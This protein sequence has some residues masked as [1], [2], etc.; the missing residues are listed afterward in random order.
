M[1][2]KSHVQTN[3]M[4]PSC[5]DLEL[6][7]GKPPVVAPEG[8]APSGRYAVMPQR[9]VPGDCWIALPHACHRSK[10]A[11]HKVLPFLHR[12]IDDA[13][14][15]AFRATEPAFDQRDVLLLHTMG[16]VL[17]DEMAKS[18]PGFTENLY[19][20]GVA[21]QAMTDPTLARLQLRGHVYPAV[22][23]MDEVC[24]RLL[25]QAAL[26]GDHKHTSWLSDS[27]EGTGLRNFLRIPPLQSG[28]SPSS[29]ILLRRAG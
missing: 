14:E 2:N 18:G 11:S 8:K 28:W 17:A 12:D 6:D 27:D 4:R 13:C 26:I 19:T 23:N 15:G 10:L 25:P 7:Q 1:A 16:A 21:V 24:R 9:R 20:A 29:Q 22:R 3:L 5:E